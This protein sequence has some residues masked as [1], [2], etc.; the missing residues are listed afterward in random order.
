MHSNNTSN[1]NEL[2][3]NFFVKLETLF[4]LTQSPEQQQ[5]SQH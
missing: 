3:E 2:A 4:M 5:L 1:N